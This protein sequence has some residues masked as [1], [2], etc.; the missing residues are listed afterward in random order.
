MATVVLV[1]KRGSA[2]EAAD[3]RLLL[4]N[5]SGKNVVEIADGVRTMHAA[6]LLHGDVTVLFERQRRLFLVTF[7]PGSLAKR[8]EQQLE[9]PQLK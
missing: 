7:D 4:F 5:P 6:T 2:L 3:G 9:V 1:K 8:R